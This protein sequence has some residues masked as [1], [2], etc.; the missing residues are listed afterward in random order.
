MLDPRCLLI[1][2]SVWIDFFLAVEP[3]CDDIAALFEMMLDRGGTLIYAP[4]TLKD[5]F[6][7]LP[8]RQR[9]MF[10]R[11][12]VDVRHISF[13]PFAWTC[14]EYMTDIAVACTQALPECSMAWML[15]NEHPDLEDNLIIAA[16][17]T[18][19]ADYVVTYDTR[20]IEHFA[21]VCITPA[22]ALRLLRLV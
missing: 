1:D 15:R 2:T 19:G 11:E 18:C 4:T 8:R 16:G 20:L 22:Q 12:G 14:V 7:L 13:R 17:E 6:Y 21:P 3:Y 9:S 10:E 5:V